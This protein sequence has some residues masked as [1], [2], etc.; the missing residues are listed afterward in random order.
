MSTYRKWDE[1]K[2]PQW[3][4]LLQKESQLRRKTRRE[5]EIER[6]KTKMEEEAIQP[7][8]SS[9]RKKKKK[10]V[11]GGENPSLKKVYKRINGELRLQIQN[12]IHSNNTTST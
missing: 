6:A 8:S 4:Y 5:I 3:K 2:S 11:K 10:R 7:S 1:S 9:N 12:E